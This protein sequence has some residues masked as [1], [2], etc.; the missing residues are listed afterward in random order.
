MFD[1]V[2]ELWSLTVHIKDCRLAKPCPFYFCTLAIDG[3][4]V[5]CTKKASQVPTSFDEQ[6]EFMWVDVLLVWFYFNLIIWCLLTG[7][8]LISCHGMTTVSYI[9]LMIFVSV[10]LS[11]RDIPRN[12]IES[13]SISVNGS[14]S[15][16]S[17]TPMTQEKIGIILF[18]FILVA[19]CASH[20]FH[21]T[22]LLYV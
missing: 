12:Y 18:Y 13:F 19:I 4:P 14:K 3:I 11:F 6:F 20:W 17:K 16:Q 21:Y 5:A 8:L 10:S 1:S 22:L 2:Q 7:C 9:V 15:L